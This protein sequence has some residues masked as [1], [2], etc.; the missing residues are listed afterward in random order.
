M[1][2]KFCSAQQFKVFQCSASAVSDT[3]PAHFVNL[4]DIFGDS[5]NRLCVCVCVCVG[6]GLQFVLFIILIW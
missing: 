3:V 4:V 5:N 2:S 6:G 1:S